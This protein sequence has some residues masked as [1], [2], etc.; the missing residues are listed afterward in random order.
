[1]K[2]ARGPGAETDGARRA[3]ALK[4]MMSMRATRVA[5]VGTNGT[6]DGASYRPGGSR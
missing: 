4:D 6:H 3:F 5:A 2:G 1:M